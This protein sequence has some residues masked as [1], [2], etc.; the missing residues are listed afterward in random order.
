[1]QI[2]QIDPLDNVAVALT[3]LKSG[4]TLQ[5]GNACIVGSESIA[6]GHKIALQ[7]ISQNET[8]IKYGQAIGKAVGPIRCGDCVHTHNLNSALSKYCLID[9]A[10]H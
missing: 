7:D 1:M 10:V 8:V 5:T 9:A 2:L 3:A 4:D 6:A